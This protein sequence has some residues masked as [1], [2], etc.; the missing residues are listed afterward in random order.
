MGAAQ[1]K[2]ADANWAPSCGWWRDPAT[3]FL[4]VWALGG[5]IA[6]QASL[7]IVSDSP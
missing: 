3:N 7:G 4:V 2:K 1:P 5:A 6:D